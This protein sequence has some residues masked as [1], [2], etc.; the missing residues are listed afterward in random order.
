MMH[1]GDQGTEGA[2]FAPQKWV[3]EA[4]RLNMRAQHIVDSPAPFTVQRWSGTGV[5]LVLFMLR[6]VLAEGWYIGA[7]CKR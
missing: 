2:A 1:E 7:W 4:H 6:I 3:H 5:L